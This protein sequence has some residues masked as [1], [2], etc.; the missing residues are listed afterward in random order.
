MG[1]SA[2]NRRRRAEANK[3]AKTD[4]ADTAMAAETP[5]SAQE[6]PGQDTS[7]QNGWFGKLGGKGGGKGGGKKK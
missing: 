5:S 2:F 7:G 1:L 3:L 4:V 6:N